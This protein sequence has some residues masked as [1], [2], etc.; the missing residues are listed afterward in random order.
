M[1]N[2]CK[3]CRA[4][5]AE[6]ARFCATCGTSLNSGEGT[7]ESTPSIKAEIE[8]GSPSA[9]GGIAVWRRFK[10]FK[11]FL[12][13]IGLVGA[14]SVIIGMIMGIAGFSTV[15]HQVSNPY[16]GGI[17]TLSAGGA[18]MGFMIA[19]VG[20]NAVI[21]VCVLRLVMFIGDKLLGES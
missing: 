17:S 11:R 7:K 16:Q 15:L 21:G 9:S 12:M 1:S 4:T 10:K 19:V 14:V 18:G 13:P 5:N 8:Y 6:D 2:T 20:L 3:K